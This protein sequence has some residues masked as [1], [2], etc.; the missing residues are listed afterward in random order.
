[1]REVPDTK[2]IEPH[3]FFLCKSFFYKKVQFAILKGLQYIIEQIIYTKT[4]KVKK[5]L[6][7]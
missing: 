4:E 5:S 6:D 3:I 7:K 1:M 2:Q